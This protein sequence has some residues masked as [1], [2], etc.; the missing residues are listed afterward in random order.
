MTNNNPRAGW[1]KI[2][3]QFYRKLPL[4][5]SIFDPDLELENYLVAGASYGG[6]LALWRDTTKIA[7][8]RTG[9][10]TKPTIDIYSSS[11]KLISNINWEKG[12]IK[13]L[14]WSDDEKLLVVTEDGTVHCY[15]G[16]HGDFQPFSLGHGAEEYGVKSCRFWSH[17]FV[18]LL[19][20][21]A[22]I[23]VSSF[24]EP[25]PRLLAPAPAGDVHSWSL[26]PPAYTLSRSVEVLLAVHKTIYVVDVTEAEDRG[27]SDG[28]FKH[29]S[30]SPNGRFAAL[31]TEDGKVWV[32]GSDF[33]HTYSEYDSKAKTTPTQIYWC[34]NDS[35]I[36]AWEDEI[37]MVGPNGTA[38]KY[39]YDDQVH[40]VPDIDGVRLL[41]NEACEFLH[42]VPDPLEE[43]F[44]LG[45][46]SAA[47]VLWDSIE[48]LEKG[49][50][51]ADENIQ[52]I[53]PLLPDA[54]ETCIRAAGHEFNPN[55][56]K[57]LLRA[58]SFGKSVLDL[59]SSDEFVDMCDDLRVLN[60]VRDYR[61]GLYMSYEQYIRLTPERLIARLVN[62]REY[63]LA[64]KLSEFLHLPLNRIYVHW[65]SQKVRGSSADDD[66]M[67]EMVVDRLRGKHGISFETIA[68]AAY[69]EGRSHLATTLLNHEPRAGRQVPLLLNME[70]DEIA[71]NKAIESGDP[72]LVFFVLLHLKKTLPLAAFLRT[73]SNKPVAAALVE[74]SARAQDK[75]LLKDLYYQDDRPVE[76]SNLLLEEAMQQSQVQAV[77]DKLKLAARLLTDAKN[78]TAVFHTKALAEAG[79]LLKMQEAWDKDMTDSSGSSVGLSVNETMFRLIQSGHSKRAAKVQSEFRVP[80]KT[81]WWLRLRALTAARLWGEVEEIGKNK[82]SPIG[83]EPFYNE[84]LGA[85]NTRLASSFIPKCTG[86]QPAERI[87]MWIK[88]GMIVKAGEEALKA[89]DMNSL[90]LLRDKANGQQLV[91]IERML[92]QLRPRK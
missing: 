28:P 76:G 88:C 32:V 49:S 73:I 17:G 42:K 31:F 71:L 29:V 92:T 78:P 61:I 19:A 15:L 25:R 21:N 69:D 55:L 10:S 20:N 80:E 60:A 70:E 8:Y 5:E 4:Y 34:G 18:A 53:K 14:G 84:I 68:R 38:A 11:G 7:R 56:Q 91:E 57:Q 27:L 48:L 58:A 63:L 65:A 39:Y 9:Q 79:Q 62:R 40:V 6:A 43:V 50:P 59:Y 44:K 37:H 30:V 47:S 23:A 35:V 51:K 83:W 33:Q 81:W 1:E 77:I 3:D 64:M 75:E 86:L 66:S 26:I 87:E 12:S 36:L 74:S 2:G 13:G 22:L 90:E 72:D 41:T 82:K 46:T 45:S 16:L 85:G 52:R 24:E 54:V 67:R 89:K